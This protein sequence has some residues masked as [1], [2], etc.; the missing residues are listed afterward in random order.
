MYML[1]HSDSGAYVL[2]GR[3][4]ARRSPSFVKTQDL[5][6]DESPGLQSHVQQA[7]FAEL[8]A[9]PPSHLLR[10][11]LPNSP[12]GELALCDQQH[13]STINRVSESV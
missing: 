12:L 4:P 8:P 6:S 2:H 1:I 3:L 5:G 10:S 7:V 9:K 13:I 11:M